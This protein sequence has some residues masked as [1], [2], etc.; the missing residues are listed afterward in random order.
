MQLPVYTIHQDDIIISIYDILFYLYGAYYLTA[1]VTTI[2][3]GSGA[4]CQCC[5]SG[6][7]IIGFMTVCITHEHSVTGGLGHQFSYPPIH[8]NDGVWSQGLG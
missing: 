5:V 4:G 6:R 2:S 1:S 3:P 7:A 8:G